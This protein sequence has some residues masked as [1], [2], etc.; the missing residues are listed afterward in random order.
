MGKAI[1]MVKEFPMPFQNRD[2]VVSFF[3][4]IGLISWYWALLDKL[5]AHHHKLPMQYN[6]VLHISIGCWSIFLSTLLLLDV[7]V[8][9]FIVIVLALLTG[10]LY[11]S[12]GLWDVWWMRWSTKKQ[13]FVVLPQQLSRVDILHHNVETAYPLFELLLGGLFLGGGLILP[14]SHLFNRISY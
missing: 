3:L 7:S 11:Y 14:L 10:L 6:H 1:Q 5:A 9:S 12:S 13:H 2:T 4:L 8:T